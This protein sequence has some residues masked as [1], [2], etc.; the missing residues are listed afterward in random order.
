MRALRESVT[1]CATPPRYG[2]CG[3]CRTG[4][5]RE[6]RAAAPSETNPKDR[7]H[8]VKAWG[9]H[10]KSAKTNPKGTPGHPGWNCEKRTQPTIDSRN[11]LERKI[12][13]FQNFLERAAPGYFGAQ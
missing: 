3:V 7:E 2:R 12:V 9:A 4:R 1:I 6:R 13:G 10:E 5:G 11:T 8:R